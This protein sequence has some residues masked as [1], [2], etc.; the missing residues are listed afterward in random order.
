[1]PDV[2]E[3]VRMWLGDRGYRGLYHPKSCCDIDC[4]CTV[5]DLM[6]CDGGAPLCRPGVEVPCECEEKH[7]G[8]HIG[9]REE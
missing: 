7:E 2:R 8:P 3:I 4:F 6:P 1:M 9:P 5:K